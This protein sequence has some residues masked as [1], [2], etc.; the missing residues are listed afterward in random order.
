MR[1]EEALLAGFPLRNAKQWAEAMGVDTRTLQRDLQFLR[2]AR[3]HRIIFDVHLEG[4]RVEPSQPRRLKT[5]ESDRERRR[6]LLRL[7]NLLSARPGLTTR[8]L[9]RALGCSVR[10]LQR[11]RRDLEEL[12]FPIS[13]GQSHLSDQGPE[14]IKP[15]EHLAILMSVRMLERTDTQ[16]G[17]LARQALGKLLR[18]G[19]T[20][21]RENP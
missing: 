11:Y 16:V 21:P 2:T 5:R 13:R 19:I 18:A 3:G 6:A 9:A 7:V 17:Y 8:D 1:L 14:D 4:Y 12:K 15:D 10:A 20:E